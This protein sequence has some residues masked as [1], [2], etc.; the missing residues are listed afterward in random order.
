MF[1]FTARN[2]LSSRSADFAWS[3]FSAAVQR[4]IPALT[5][6]KS[7]GH[8]LEHLETLPLTA[9]SSV[10]LIRAGGETLLLGITP[11]GISLLAKNPASAVESSAASDAPL[12]AQGSRR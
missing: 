8:R 10:A 4:V 3:S 2:S 1:Q 9:H 5:R 12:D 7:A 6:R 11:Q